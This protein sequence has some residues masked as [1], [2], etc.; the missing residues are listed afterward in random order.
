[1]GFYGGC[2]GASGGMF[3][4]DSHDR[5]SSYLAAAWISQEYLYLQLQP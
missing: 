5:H 4:G 3:V 2:G 1:M